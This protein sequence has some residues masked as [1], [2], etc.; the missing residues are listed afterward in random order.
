[1]LFQFFS[2]FGGWLVRLRAGWQELEEE[3]EEAEEQ[4]KRFKKSVKSSDPIPIPA[5][6]RSV[7]QPAAE[8]KSVSYP[9]KWI[10]EDSGTVCGGLLETQSRAVCIARGSEISKIIT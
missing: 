3:P 8:R 10:A 4:Q 7:Y 6:R 1:M 9:R 5:S 2:Y